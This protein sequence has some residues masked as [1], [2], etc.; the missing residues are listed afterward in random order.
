MAVLAVVGLAAAGAAHDRSDDSAGRSGLPSIGLTLSGNDIAHFERIYDRLRGSNPDSPFYRENNRWRRAQ[1][2]YDGTVYNVRVKSHGRIPD[3]H[4]VERDGHRFISLSIRMAPGDRVAGLNRFKLIVRENL[5]ETQQLVMTAA[6]EAHVLVQDHRLVRVRINNRREKLFYF[7]N[8][9][10]DEY[11]ESAGQASLRTVTYDYD[12]GLSDKSLVLT[13]TVQYMDTTFDFEEH[14]RRALTQMGVL[15]DDWDPLLR[16]YS[17]F[18]TAIRGDSAADPAEF[19]DLEYLGRYEAIRYVLGLD[20]H[21]F[22]R[23]NLRVFLNTANGKFYPALSGRDDYP[24]TLDLSGSRTPEQQLNTDTDIPLAV[25]MFHFVASSDRVRQVI[26]RAVYR[27]IVEDGARLIQELERGLVEGGALAPAE[28]AIVRSVARDGSTWGAA[29]AGSGLTVGRGESRA[30]LTSNI[31]SLRQ[32][33][34]RSAPAYSAQLS[35]GRIVLEIRPDSM[36]ELSVKTLTVGVRAGTQTVD[37]PVRVHVTEDPG[38]KGDARS[39]SAAVDWLANGRLD[40]SRALAQARFAT[41]LDRSI[42]PPPPPPPPRINVRWVDGL[43]ADRRRGLEARFGLDAED[44]E[45]STWSYGLADASHENITAV[46]Q[47]PDVEDTNYIDRVEMTLEAG[48]F[49]V[50][51]PRYRAPSQERVPRLYT[52]ALTVT[53]VA[54]DDLRPEDI[55]LVFVNAVTGQEV[56]A[57]R[58]ASHDVGDVPSRDGPAALPSAPAV[59]AWLAAHPHLDIRQTDSGELRLRRGTYRLPEHLV[60]PRGYDLHIESGTDLQLGAGVV[61]LVR[62]GLHI[63]GSADQPV[64]IR[65]IEPGQPFGAVAVVGDGIQRT[66]VTYLELSGGSDAWLDG[67]HFAGALSIHYQDWVSVSHT[68]IRDNRGADGLSIKYA[69]GAVSDSSFTGNRDDQVDLEYFDGIV[70]DSRFESAPSGDPNGDGLDLRGSRVVVVNNELT[71]AADKA[72]SVGEESEVLF[73]ANRVGH[74]AIGVAVKDLSTAYLYDNRFEENRRDVRATM[75]KPFF[76]GGRVVFA[77]TGPRQADLSVDIDD[78]STLTRIP[79]DAVERL[80]P[81]DMRPE[82]VVESLRALSAVSEGR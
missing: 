15:R 29:T 18:N 20:V 48:A 63:G 42:P 80:E 33:L 57:R 3:Y 39:A 59:E 64:T 26:Y 11:A 58:V 47:H 27:F 24:L 25:L 40:V 76:G 53:G 22:V 16:R 41:G 8:L 35:R 65:S 49:R 17:A 1:L 56:E 77:G 21:G 66:E 78:E 52:L 38:A 81:T 43:D 4:S 74:S 44:G 32:Y 36:S 61:L 46:V 68:K 2:R 51:E 75:K 62:G 19:F 67:A 82:R 79:A 7:S 37:T 54:A 9:L 69:A 30:V 31:Q 10:D 72:A 34:E 70:R 23:D 5:T 55:D 50:A 13:D 6:R 73:V 14:F 12:D 28:L 45:S 71:G 60:L